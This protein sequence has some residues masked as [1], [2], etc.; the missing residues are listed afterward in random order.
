MDAFSVSGRSQTKRLT[1]YLT[2]NDM[3]AEG[4]IVPPA[5]SVSQKDRRV[6]TETMKELNNG[7][8]LGKID[9]LPAG[10][11]HFKDF[12]QTF[13]FLPYYEQVSQE[14]WTYISSIPGGH[15]DISDYDILVGSVQLD[16][17]NPAADKVREFT[18]EGMDYH[19][20]WKN[21]QPGQPLVLLDSSGNSL[22]EMNMPA[23]LEHLDQVYRDGKETVLSDL[24]Y[25]TET[26]NGA[27]GILAI[28]GHMD[29]GSKS[30]EYSINVDIYIRIG[31]PK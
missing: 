22:V 21:N 18:V 23:L 9:Y 5:A 12:N 17:S 6:I 4:K 10:Y 24:I 3:L 2:K 16:S 7:G 15:L 20:E 25:R 31:P 11:D 28:E 26:D 13:G 14:E 30:S 1:E 27:L 19:I 29:R 8:W